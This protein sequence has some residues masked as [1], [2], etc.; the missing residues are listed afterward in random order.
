MKLLKQLSLLLIL[1]VASLSAA[2][3]ISLVD[4]EEEYLRVEEAFTA[5]VLLDGDNL[6]VDWSIAPG[7]F[8]YKGQFKLQATTPE[9]K[10]ILAPHYEKGKEKFDEIFKKDVELYYNATRITVNAVGLSDKFELQLRSQG[11]AD[12]GLCYP[13]RSQY[14]Q[15]DKTTGEIS[16]TPKSTTVAAENQATEQQVANAVVEEAVSASSRQIDQPGETEETHSLLFYILLAIGGGIV[17]N[18]MPCVFP[19]LSLKALSFASHADGPNSHQAHGWAYTA[20]VI[21]SFVLAAII[22]LLLRSAGTAAG[23]GFQL[24]SPV[25][26]AVITYLFLVMGLSLSGMIYFGTGLMG[27]GQNLA[28]SG[29][30]KG[31]FFTGVLAA[32]VASPCTGP[33]MAPA[34]GFALTQPPHVAIIIFIALGFGLALPFLA[35]SYSPALARAL[36]APGNWMETL[37]QFLAFPMYI[38]A[39][40]LLYVFGN[41][42]GMTGAF[43][44]VLGGI[45]IVYA[46]WVFQRAPQKGTLKWVAQLSGY[47][48]LACAA[49]VA[50]AG[51]SFKKDDSWINFTPTVV[52]ELRD[53]GHP[54]F[55]DFTADWCITCK[56]NEAI[57]IN[58]DEFKEVAEKYNFA[59]V[60]GDWTN[61]NPNITAVLTQYKRSGVPLYLVYPADTGKPAEVLPQILTL[62]MV[63]KALEH[64]GS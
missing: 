4:A 41:Q 15:I 44:L 40:W 39:A 14:F 64:N 51:E 56:A 52:Q 50:Y 22:I 5:T 18:L 29:G 36:P 46:I 34:L 26:V 25:F 61:E 59:K 47:G 16:E 1:A 42:V 57:A 58:R 53:K 37:K 62:N 33:M 2:A 3:S 10:T 20:G 6:Y 17:L 32:L 11:C 63:I 55:V 43:F 49:Y 21:G 23:W 54:V 13:P 35:L 28:S 60:K 9:T 45:S 12:A 24:Q 38:T 27:V 8:L 31:S 30:L 19:V 7:Y 48:A